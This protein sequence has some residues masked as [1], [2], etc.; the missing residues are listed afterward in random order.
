MLIV[1]ANGW[2][3]HRCSVES[4]PHER[5]CELRAESERDEIVSVWARSEYE[6]VCD[7]SEKTCT[8]LSMPPMYSDCPSSLHLTCERD[9]D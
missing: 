7:V 5:S 8:S 9:S 6:M 2:I 3:D 1:G 4:M